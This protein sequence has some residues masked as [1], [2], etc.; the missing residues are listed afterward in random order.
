MPFPFTRKPLHIPDKSF[1]LFVETRKRTRLYLIIIPVAFLIFAAGMALYKNHLDQD[2]A[3]QEALTS[4]PVSVPALLTYAGAAE[5]VRG[6]PAQNPAPARKVLQ[7]QVE[8]VEAT[9]RAEV[10]ENKQAIENAILDWKQAWESSNVDAYLSHYANDFTPEDGSSLAQWK[11]LRSK[12][13]QAPDNIEI[14]LSNFDIQFESADVASV[15]FDQ[16]YRS[17]SF[18]DN[19]RKQLLVRQHEGA[20]KIERE[21][22]DQP[23]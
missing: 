10:A 5:A 7:Q 20:W 14:T 6:M 16:A 9:K 2:S 12:R 18:T 23:E 8:D 1:E 19:T 17:K 4:Q 13:L 3:M 11:A 22:S 21:T 15:A